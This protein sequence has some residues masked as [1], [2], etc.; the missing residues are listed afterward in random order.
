MPASVSHLNHFNNIVSLLKFTKQLQPPAGIETI[1]HLLY[2]LARYKYRIL[3]STFNKDCN[4]DQAHTRVAGC[5]EGINAWLPKWKA[6]VDSLPPNPD[7]GSNVQVA[8]LLNLYGTFYHSEAVL[9]YKQTWP[10]EMA[11]DKGI[12]AARQMIRSFSGLQLRQSSVELLT[13]QKS[14]PIMCPLPWP[15]VHSLCSAGVFLVSKAPD[16]QQDERLEIIWD[17]VDLCISLLASLQS[18]VDWGA[19]GLSA[20]LDAASRSSRSTR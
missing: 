1:P 4:K 5:K 17:D 16:L 18:N 20:V 9:L 13:C 14:V 6:A 8:A 7:I 12:A 15:A 2:E 19:E 3:L 11:L 10:H